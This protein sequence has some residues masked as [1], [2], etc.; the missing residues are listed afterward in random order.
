M[1]VASPAHDRVVQQRLK[2]W[3]VPAPMAVENTKEA[4]QILLKNSELAKIPLDELPED[5]LLGQ[6][7]ALWDADGSDGCARAACETVSVLQASGARQSKST[8]HQSE[9]AR[10]NGCECACEQRCWA[11]RRGLSVFARAVCRPFI[12]NMQNG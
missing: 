9:H 11:D 10:A 4:H 12:A 2:Y 1:V 5:D 6:L 3:V 7:N 8:R